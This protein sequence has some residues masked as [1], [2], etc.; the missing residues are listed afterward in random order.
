MVF[1]TF[2]ADQV[3]YKSPVVPGMIAAEKMAEEFQREAEN[4]KTQIS[5]LL[6]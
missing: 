3:T 6:H 1:I 4:P 2:K 5:E